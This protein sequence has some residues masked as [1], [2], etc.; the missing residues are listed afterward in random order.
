LNNANIERRGTCQRREPAAERLDPSAISE[1]ALDIDRFDP[2]VRAHE[3]DIAQEMV[4]DIG[5]LAPDFRLGPKATDGRAPRRESALD[6]PEK[7]W[8]AALLLWLAKPLRNLLF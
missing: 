4:V 7:N 1:T 3:P 5:K 8:P 2:S 6:T